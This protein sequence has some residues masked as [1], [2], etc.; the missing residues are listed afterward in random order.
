MDT[1]RI[2]GFA[3]F[4]TAPI[5]TASNAP[6]S[7]PVPYALLGLPHLYAIPA[8][9]VI[10]K[11]Q[12]TRLHALFAH[13]PITTVSN[14]QV[15]VSA[16]SAPSVMQCQLVPIVPLDTRVQVVSTVP[17]DTIAILIVELAIHVLK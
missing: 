13:K 5:L 4:V 15:Q 6:V 7:L 3:T 9:S 8:L 10:M 2:L 1:T 11:P 12:R 17:L 14:V 16:H